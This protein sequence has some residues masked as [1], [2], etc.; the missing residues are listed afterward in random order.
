MI[1]KLPNAPKSKLKFWLLIIGLLLAPFVIFAFMLF[2]RG[3]TDDIV[4]VAD[5]FK[6]DSS[7]RLVDETVNP[8][9]I[10]CIDSVCPKVFRSWEVKNA[11]DRSLRD[12]IAASGWGFPI[13]GS[14]MEDPNTNGLATACSVNGVV[15]G[16][17]I[18]ITYLRDSSGYSTPRIV[19][20]LEK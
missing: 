8:P 3:S 14:C 6:P 15:D 18:R 11:N 7:W 20:S 1:K 13:E 5:Q 17:D 2:Y 4:R 10:I 19:L 16:Y 9:Q 12:A